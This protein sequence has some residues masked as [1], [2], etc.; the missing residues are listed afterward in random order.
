MPEVGLKNEYLVKLRNYFFQKA[1]GSTN[2]HDLNIALQGLKLFET[3][4]FVHNSGKNI[5]SLND[6]KTSLKYDLVDL[7]GNPF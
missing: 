2:V 4:P 7:F 3:I 1:T 6:A 5:L